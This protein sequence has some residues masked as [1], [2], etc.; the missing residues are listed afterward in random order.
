MRPVVPPPVWDAGF[1]AAMMLAHRAEPIA[2]ASF[3]G[4][5][6]LGVAAATSGIALAVWGVA[7]FR[8]HRTTVNPLAPTR[9]SSLVTSGPF[10][11]TR[12]PM[13][14][15]MLLVLVGAAVWLGSVMAALFL[16]LFVLVLT[17][18]QVRPEEAAMREL[19]GEPYL[20]YAARVPR[21][22]LV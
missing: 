16:P 12:N 10:R 11:F 1:L 13:Y 14:V 9:A 19:F 20:A 18:V 5:G 21:W 17:L 2:A 3:P 8:R 7:T 15:G 6:A 22:V 4:Q